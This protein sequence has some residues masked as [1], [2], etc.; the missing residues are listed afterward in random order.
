MRW[1]LLL[2]VIACKRDDAASPLPRRDGGRPSDVNAVALDDAAVAKA[3]PIATKIVVGDDVSCVVMSEGSLRCWG[4][5]GDGQLGNGTTVD[6]PSPV[7]SKLRGVKDVVLGARHACALLDDESVTCW[8]GIQFGNADRL[9][10]RAAPGVSKAKRI[11]AV[12]GASCATTEPGPLVCWGDVDVAGH[13]RLAGGAADHRMPTPSRGL[14]HV[15]ALTATGALHEDGS[16]SFWRADGV[17]VKTTLSGVTEIA[18]W[19][20]RICGLRKDGSVACAGPTPRCAVVAKPA[21]MPAKSAK[22]TKGKRKPAPKTPPKREPALVVETVPLPAAK[23]L[24]FDAGPCVVTTTGKLECVS[25][26]DPCTAEA[27]WPGLANVEM[28]SGFCARARG[29]A[30]RCWPADHKTRVVR[31]VR[32]VE[33]VIDLAASS[34]HACAIRSDRSVAC[35]GNNKHGA[36]GR[37]KAAD[38]IAAEASAIAQ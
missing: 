17:P 20:D 27:Q 16:V 29:G 26:T 33:S 7:T 1:L 31:A 22:P 4:N 3:T 37:G 11:F 14:D 30:V 12:G 28:V 32:G 8:G 19:G 25:E 23:H 6:S 35:W 5:N 21:A 15:T 24:A 2:A 13:L 34:S 38:E 9:S 36:L 18:S 10:P